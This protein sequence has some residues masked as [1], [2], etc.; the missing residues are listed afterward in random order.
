MKDGNKAFKNQGR[1]EREQVP[2]QVTIWIE[3]G[4]MTVKTSTVNKRRAK[5]RTAKKA[6]RRNR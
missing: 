5:N 6:R 4:M 1:P 3:P 2:N